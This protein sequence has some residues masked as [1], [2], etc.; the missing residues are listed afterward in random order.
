MLVAAMSLVAVIWAAALCLGKAS[1]LTSAIHAGR[2][3]TFKECMRRSGGGDDALRGILNKATP[4]CKQ[5]L[6][7]F[8][9]HRVAAVPL[10]RASPPLEN[11]CEERRSRG[12]T[13][14][15]RAFEFQRVSHAKI[16]FFVLAFGYPLNVAPSEVSA[17][18]A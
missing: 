7:K 12:P 1:L 5:G 4:S 14:R 9:C 15:S 6:K 3:V 10:I 17:V 18:P 13:Q 16:V 8:Y 11:F 2:N